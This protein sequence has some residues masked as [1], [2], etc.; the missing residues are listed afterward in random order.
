MKIIYALSSV[1][2]LT[3]LNIVI[4]F[5]IVSRGVCSLSERF[6]DD[7]NDVRIVSIYR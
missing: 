4:A 5:K 2:Y 6:V 7:L 1:R 3:L